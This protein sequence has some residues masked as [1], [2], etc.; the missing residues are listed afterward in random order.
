VIEEALKRQL[1]EKEKIQEC[2]EVEAVSLRKELQE[3][4]I[5]AGFII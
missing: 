3:K 1:E 2:L 5:F 4:D